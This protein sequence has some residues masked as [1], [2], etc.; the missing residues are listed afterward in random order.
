MTDSISRFT[1]MQAGTE[2]GV[3][4]WHRVT[5]QDVDTFAQL[6]HDEDPY[7]N[8]PEWARQSSP[9]G[10]TISFGF[11]TLAMLSYFAHQVLDEQ[12]MGS[13]SD[14]QMLNFGFNRV[15]MPEPVPV[16]SEI[17]GSFVFAGARERSAGALEFTLTASVEIRGK[18]RPALVA[19]W[20]FVAMPTG[21]AANVA[22]EN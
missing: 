2:L 17:R 3:S 12:G 19:E 20:L 8:D 16:G 14:T 18:E 5:Q 15:R 1:N 6:T 21:E 13:G 9:L 4:A 10:T 7:H 11:F 22:R